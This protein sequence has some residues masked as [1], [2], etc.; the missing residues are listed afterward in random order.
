MDT[1]DWNPTTFQK[2]L[3]RTTNQIVKISSERNKDHDSQIKLV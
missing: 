1:F 3:V 2:Y